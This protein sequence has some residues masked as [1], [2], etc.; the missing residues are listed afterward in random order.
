MSGLLLA[1][2]ILSALPAGAFPTAGRLNVDV[3]GVAPAVED[4]APRASLEVAALLEAVLEAVRQQ[5]SPADYEARAEEFREALAGRTTQFLLTYRITG[6]PFLR[7]ATPDPGEDLEGRPADPEIE[8]EPALEWPEFEESGAEEWVLPLNA[9]IDT[10]RLREYLTG[11]GLLVAWDARPSVVLDVR[12]SAG[13][14]PGEAAGPLAELRRYLVRALER[15]EVVVVEPGVRGTPLS[16]EE[17]ALDLARALGADIGLEVGVRWWPTG[18]GT[19]GGVAEVS[20]RA[21]RASDAA[22]LALSRFQGAGYHE[23]APEALQ[24]ALEAV[25]DQVAENVL[26]QLSRNWSEL[27]RSSGPVDAVLL[28]VSSLVHV[29]AVRSAIEFGLD[30]EEAVLSELGPRRARLR[31]TAQLSAGALQDRLTAMAFDGFRLQ[32]VEVS[33]DQIVMRVRAEPSAAEAAPGEPLDA[34]D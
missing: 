21:R 9:T 3:E 24:R 5:T 33:P 34:L 10:R 1:A 18:T 2:A 17:D 7:P 14:D 22:D 11:R 28:D 29:D 26:L 13:L 8:A 30:A 32:P 12:G 19:S 4:R 31:V 16:G 23:L 25:R 20:V 27:A 6:S 15:G